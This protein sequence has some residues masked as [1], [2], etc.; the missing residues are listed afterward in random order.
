MMTAGRHCLRL[1][2]SI[3]LLACQASLQA[4]AQGTHPFAVNDL[5]AVCSNPGD[6]AQAR[7]ITDPHAHRVALS[8][9]GAGTG[10]AKGE[11]TF[12]NTLFENVQVLFKGDC[13]E[14]LL[15]ATLITRI[16]FIKPGTTTILDHGYDCARNTINVRPDGITRVL[17]NTHSVC[18][19]DDMIPPGSRLVG[20]NLELVCADSNSD[21][22]H[23]EMVYGLAVNNHIVPF[24]FRAPSAYCSE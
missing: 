18:D 16:R 7:F 12:I 5:I 8:L 24:D 14:D 22:T 19:C 6:F 13:S 11:A 9:T 17:I 1:I 20:V 4:Q 3:L 2:V 15:P 23:S 21:V 10:V